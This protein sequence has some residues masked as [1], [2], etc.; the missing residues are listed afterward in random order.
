MVHGGAGVRHVYSVAVSI[1]A[2]L[3]HGAREGWEATVPG[4]EVRRKCGDGG[5]HI[6]YMCELLLRSIT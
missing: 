6:S 4:A 1:R 5:I 2:T 3:G